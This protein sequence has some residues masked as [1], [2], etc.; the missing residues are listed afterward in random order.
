MAQQARAR[1]NGVGAMLQTAKRAVGRAATAVDVH[2]T[3][4]G[5][6]GF[7]LADADL[8]MSGAT[9]RLLRRF[10]FSRIHQ[11]RA[12]NFHALAQ[13]A[14]GHVTPLQ[15]SLPHGACPLFLP[16]VVGDKTAAARA[17]QAQGVQALEFWNHGAG[18]RVDGGADARYLRTH[19]LALPVHQD[20]SRR[21]VEHMASRLAALSSQL[22]V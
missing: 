3:T 21:H 8:G 10:D 9:G 2:R 22:A 19:V 4:V 17:L 16:I 13:A 12:A 18:G 1:L 15:P 5:D 11:A 14:K 7:T 20:L 6:I